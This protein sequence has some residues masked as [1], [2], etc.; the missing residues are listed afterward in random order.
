MYFAAAS[1]TL[2]LRHSHLASNDAL[3]T[4]LMDAGCQILAVTSSRHGSMCP[5]DEQEYPKLTSFL[6]NHEK[7][8]MQS[9]CDEN[10]SNIDVR[11]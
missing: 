4:S 10:K 6:L 3:V 7:L 9:K 8:A 11:Y 1:T 2:L 5:F